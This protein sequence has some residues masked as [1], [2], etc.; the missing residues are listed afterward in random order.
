MENYFSNKNVILILWKWKW[1][2]ITVV[3]VAILLGA[4]F[5]SK[6][7]ITPKFD[8][9]AVIY[10][11]NVA[12]Y[13]DESE[14]E[15]MIQW[16]QSR[17]IKDSMIKRYD[18]GRHYEIDTGYKYYYTT[19][20]YEYN[21][22]VSISKT[23]YESIE[24]E[25]LDKNPVQA[26]EMVESILELLNNKIRRIHE[27]K[28]DE[29]LELNQRMVA[30]KKKEVDSVKQVLTE[31]G[32][33]YGLFE[34]ESQ[35]REVTEGYLRTVDG[36]SANINHS[37]VQKLKKALEEKGG[38]FMINESYVTG[39]M[40]GYSEIKRD[41]DMAYKNANRKFTYTN[42]VTSPFVSDKKAYPVRWL[43]VVYSVVAALI[44]AV[45]VIA[46]LENKKRLEFKD[47]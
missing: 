18:L 27:S 22:N 19:L 8:S 3:A 34:T 20:L 38:E 39:L 23:Q 40:A 31:L 11:S 17:D 35:A 36:S 44:L 41:Y 30:K 13:S 6:L 42:T 33:D 21:Q 28:F 47:E 5:S 14:T 46:V 15:Q 24:I 9:R 29:V 1:H 43:I 37:G 32:M 2:L 4:I 16:L 10:P 7:F 25:V 12:P 26:K 45:I